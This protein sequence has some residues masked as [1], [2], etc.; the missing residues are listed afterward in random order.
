M[1]PIIFWGRHQAAKGRMSGVARHAT[2]LIQMGD[3]CESAQAD[4]QPNRRRTGCERVKATKQQHV[5]RSS[6]GD[7]SAD[8]GGEVFFLLTTPLMGD[9][10]FINAVTLSV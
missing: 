10:N 1:V 7:G 6:C 5:V 2:A 3:W 4:R 8:S 9:P